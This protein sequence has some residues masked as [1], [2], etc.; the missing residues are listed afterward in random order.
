[1]LYKISCKTRSMSMHEA[2]R[3]YT[4]TP[5]GYAK[6]ED[7]RIRKANEEVKERQ[8]PPHEVLKL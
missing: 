7:L 4:R 2:A 6:N 5:L 8:A 1:V 3:L